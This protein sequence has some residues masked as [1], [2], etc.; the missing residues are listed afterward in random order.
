MKQKFKYSSEYDDII[1]YTDGF[2]RGDKGLIIELGDKA[3]RKLVVCK[4]ICWSDNPEWYDDQGSLVEFYDCDV[5]AEFCTH[6]DII[7]VYFNYAEN[8]D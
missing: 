3:E 8:E 1:V 6:D 4:T 7:Y 2:S 5:S